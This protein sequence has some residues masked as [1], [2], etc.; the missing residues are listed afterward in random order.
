MKTLVGSHSFLV[1]TPN[2]VMYWNIETIVGKMLKK[3]KQTSD[4]SGW[5]GWTQ[6]VSHGEC[7]AIGIFDLVG[8][9]SV[10]IS[11]PSR[12]YMD[13]ML[14]RVRPTS[15]LLVALDTKLCFQVAELVGKYYL[16]IESLFP[17]T[18]N[19]TRRAAWLPCWCSL[20]IQMRKPK[21]GT[22]WYPK[23]KCPL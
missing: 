20:G 8:T 21:G 13:N 7:S 4:L 3:P 19:S 23:S 15:P 18:E 10:R 22:P 17:W 14:F 2:R 6:K 5:M 9:W 16:L 11:K 1:S 12:F